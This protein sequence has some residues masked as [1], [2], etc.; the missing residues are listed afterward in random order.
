MKITII[1]LD[2]IFLSSLV[3]IHKR[4]GPKTLAKKIPREK[5]FSKLIKS[6]I[7]KLKD[8]DKFFKNPLS[9]CLG[10]QIR[11]FENQRN[12]FFGEEMA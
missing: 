3:G 8:F 5:N 9:F 2:N 7:E 6:V 4:I 10:N 12:I 1:Y 11:H